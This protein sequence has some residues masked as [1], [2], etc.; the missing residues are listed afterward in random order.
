[1]HAVQ[2]D[3]LIIDTRNHTEQVRNHCY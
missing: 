3:G 1:M 2:Y